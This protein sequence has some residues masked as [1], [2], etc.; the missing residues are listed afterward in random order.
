MLDGFIVVLDIQGVLELKINAY[1]TVQFN[2]TITIECMSEMVKVQ[3]LSLGKVLTK[4][5]SCL[6]LFKFVGVNLSMFILFQIKVFY[7]IIY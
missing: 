4:I 1:I 5:V 2:G 7:C 6:I 3:L